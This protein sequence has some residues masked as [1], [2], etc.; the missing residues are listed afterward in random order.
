MLVFLSDLHLTDGSTCT[1]ISQ[2]AFAHFVADLKWMIEQ[3]CQRKG[4]K[5]EPL[6]RVDL[7][8]LGDIVDL[9]RTRAWKTAPVVDEH[10]LRPWTPEMCPPARRDEAHAELAAFIRERTRAVVHHNNG[11]IKERTLASGH[12]THEV[13]PDPEAGG[14]ESLRLLAENGVSVTDPTD[15][16]KVTKIPVYLWYMAGNHDWFYAV[17]RREYT[18]ARRLLVDALG[19]RN[20]ADAPFPHTMDALPQEL[21]EQLREHRVF[22]QHGDIDDPT[23]FQAEGE[24]MA[25]LL[26]RSRSSLGDAIVIELIDFLEE[27]LLERLSNDPIVKDKA[28]QQALKEIDNVRPLLAIPQWLS[29]VIQRFGAK[30]PDGHAQRDAIVLEVVRSRLDQMLREP[31]VRKLD[32]PLELDTVDA[33]KAGKVVARYSSLDW[34]AWMTEKLERGKSEL[35]ERI[36]YRAHALGHLNASGERVDYVVMGHT[37]FPDVA[38]LD[39]EDDHGRIYINTGTWRPIHSR[40]AGREREFV[41][42]HVMSYAAIYRDDERKGRRYETWTGTLGVGQGE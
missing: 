9:L 35:R 10:R 8:L 39:L 17:D 36:D 41:S 34:L 20:D 6:P 19:L 37:H 16:K 31:F 40:C 33:L 42:A 7:I 1:T 18:E 26:R 13:R 28:F 30:Y 21:R 2:H 38:P 5:F 23:N 11:L 12:V 4:S 32:R 24:D 3:A 22:A 27:E 14:L 29:A 25:P 15:G